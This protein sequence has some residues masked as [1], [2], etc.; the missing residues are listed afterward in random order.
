MCE[1]YISSYIKLLFV[2]IL[3]LNK[4]RCDMLRLLISENDIQ[5]LQKSEMLLETNIHVLLEIMRYLK[6]DTWKLKL[7]ALVIQTDKQLKTSNSMKYLKSN[8]KK[9]PRLCRM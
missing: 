6:F 2:Y 9:S 5:N 1:I 8:L 4:K 7:D 3:F